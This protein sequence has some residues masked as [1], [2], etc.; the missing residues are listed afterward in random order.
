[1][2]SG[3]VLGCYGEVEHNHGKEY[4]GRAELFTSW[5]PEAER[6]RN[7]LRTRYALQRHAPGDFLPSTRPTSL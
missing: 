5:K 1:M 3:S 4:G 7:S 6:E 2:V